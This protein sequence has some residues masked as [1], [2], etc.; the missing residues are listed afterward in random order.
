RAE[1]IEERR[2]RYDGWANALGQMVMVE[3]TTA[4]REGK[5]LGAIEDSL[6]SLQRA[7]NT[8]AKCFEVSSKALGKDHAEN[9]EEE[10]PNLVF[11]E[12]TPSQ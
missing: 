5:P 10:I 12:L 9:D 11:G 6:K 2:T 3:V 8:L 4:K 1:K 7:S